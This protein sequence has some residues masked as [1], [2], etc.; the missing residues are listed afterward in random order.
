MT[1]F[2]SPYSYPIL[3][4]GF[5]LLLGGEQFSP[6][7]ISQQSCAPEILLNPIKGPKAGGREDDCTLKG[8]N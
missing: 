1:L 4:Y 8:C 3:G 2:S 5:Q 6:V 7:H